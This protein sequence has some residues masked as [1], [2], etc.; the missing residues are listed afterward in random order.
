MNMD[1]K[2]YVTTVKSIAEGYFDEV[3]NY[4]P[5]IGRGNT[6]RIFCKLV[7]TS[8]KI[9]KFNTN[10][11]GAFEYVDKCID[12][13]G[14]KFADALK[15]KDYLSFGS[16][17]KD[18][19]KVVAFRLKKLSR[20]NKFETALESIINKVSEINNNLNHKDIEKV[21]DALKEQKPLDESAIVKKYWEQKDEISSV[22]GEPT[23]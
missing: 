4:I 1:F 2:T 7:S 19:E 22:D 21:L 18:A 15:D 17:V 11:I 20:E 9:K 16:A 23:H 10:D 14:D 8:N 5:E 13:V 6:L 12:I 3:N